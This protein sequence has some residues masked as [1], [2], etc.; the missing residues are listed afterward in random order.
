MTNK[1]RPDCS[2]HE[3]IV[4]IIDVYENT[5]DNIK[6][7][8]IVL[9]YLEGGDLLGIFESQQSRPYSEERLAEIMR[10]VSK[11]AKIGPHASLCTVSERSLF[12]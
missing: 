7:L 6:C 3:N 4:S 12:C 11:E 5:I 9:E 1:R 8:L 10:Q 2:H